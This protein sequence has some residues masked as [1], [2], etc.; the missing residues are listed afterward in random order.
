MTK[1]KRT[2]TDWIASPLT[3]LAMTAREATAANTT[4]GRKKEF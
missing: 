1:G 2:M 4:F 3:G